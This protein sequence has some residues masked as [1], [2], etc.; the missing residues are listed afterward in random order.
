MVSGS[1]RHHRLFG[2]R[3]RCRQEISLTLA[4]VV[5][6]LQPK[7]KA[8]QRTTY[9]VVVVEQGA[10]AS[11]SVLSKQPAGKS[12]ED[13]KWRNT[14]ISGGEMSAPGNWVFRKTSSIMTAVETSLPRHYVKGGDNPVTLMVRH[15]ANTPR[16][17]EWLRDVVGVKFLEDK[18]PFSNLAPFLPRRP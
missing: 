17:A 8:R 15:S 16:V 1:L 6:L 14:L 10:R 11:F 7:S 9:D 5:L 2:S 4:E 18:S 13:A 12:V 3:P